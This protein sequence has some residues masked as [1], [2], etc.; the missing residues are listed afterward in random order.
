M[1]LQVNLYELKNYFK[2]SKE[3][4]VCLIIYCYIQSNK[5]FHISPYWKSKFSTV[6]SNFD[7]NK[8]S[9]QLNLKGKNQ[10]FVRNIN[11]PMLM[12]LFH[13]FFLLIIHV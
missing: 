5:S 9:I 1:N 7:L 2:A 6:W 4:R 13:C 12:K 8:S 11:S 3:Q 10:L